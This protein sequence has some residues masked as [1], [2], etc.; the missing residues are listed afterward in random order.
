MT[1]TEV[2]GK[3]RD[4][5]TWGSGLRH[6]RTSRAAAGRIGTPRGLGCDDGTPVGGNPAQVAGWL[7]VVHASFSPHVPTMAESASAPG[8]FAVMKQHWGAARAW[9]SAAAVAATAMVIAGCGS[10]AAPGGGTTSAPPPTSGTA[11]GAVDLGALQV[12]NY[13]V[14]PNAPLG[15]TGTE[16][17]GR[18]LQAR[19]MANFVVG[20]WEIDP[21]LLQTYTRFSALVLKNADALTLIG[22]QGVADAAGRHSFVNGFYSARTNGSTILINAVVRFA[23]EAAATAAAQDMVQ[24]AL[25]EPASGATR[26]SVTIPGHPDSRGS[27]Y[28]FTDVLTHREQATVQAY[29][30][31]GVYVLVQRAQT[32]DGLDAARTLAS[33]TLDAQIPMIDQFTPAALADFAN[34]P[35]DPTGLLA[36]T[37]LQPPK[38]ADVV[39]NA[40]YDRHG[41]LHFLSDPVATVGVLTKTGTD[42][43]AEGLTTVY[44]AADAAGAV[45]LTEAFD[46][47]VTGTDG[48][49]A[50]P[51]KGLPTSKCVKTSVEH[52][53]VASYDRYAFTAQG[54]QLVDVHQK[55]AAQYAMLAAPV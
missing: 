13:P 38:E 9:R 49:P 15:S 55:I 35:L 18:Q 50:D 42:L 51:V 22:P 26:S 54:V 31:H 47:Q 10:S 29:T 33:R 41:E 39:H 32:Y 53:C 11:S 52:F 30:P 27:S 25:A 2:F 17:K 6:R 45:A 14:K 48:S 12:G 37:L 8:K 7:G 28:P 21:T 5:S 20:P 43:V 23:D 46:K 34:L 44:Q 16:S 3:G 1:G 4:I 36:R 19:Q 40:T 24:S